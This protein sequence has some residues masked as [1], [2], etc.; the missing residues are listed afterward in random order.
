VARVERRDDTFTLTLEDI[1]PQEFL[2]TLI[3]RDIPVETFEVA[4]AS[5]QDIFIAVVKER[6][7]A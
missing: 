4:T 1:T 6:N 7:H 2:Q 5:L 3:E